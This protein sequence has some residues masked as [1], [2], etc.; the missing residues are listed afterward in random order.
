MKSKK[1][2]VV[3]AGLQGAAAAL[4]LASTGIKVDL[5]EREP[6][7]V[8][9]ASAQNECKIHLGYVFAKDTSLA[10][11]RVLSK[12]AFNFAPL[13]RRW[14]G[15]DF[16]KISVSAPFHYLVHKD[17]IVPV[18]EL[19]RFYEAVY[20]INLE[21]QENGDYLG[22]TVASAP[23]LVSGREDDGLYNPARVQ[24]VFRTHELGIDP[25]QLAAL[26][27]L[28]LAAQPDIRVITDAVVAE[29]QPSSDEVRLA[30][31][32]AGARHSESYD[33]VVNTAWDGRLA[34]D[35]KINLVPNRPWSF[36][37]KHFLRLEVDR[38]L[39]MPST[40]I[41]LGPFGDMVNYRNGAFHL[42]WYPAGMRGMSAD[43]VPPQ[44]WL[45]L[46]PEQ[47]AEVREGIM[48]GLVS[49]VPRLAMLKED[50]LERA[51]ISGGVIFAW[52]D[53]DIDDP[54]SELHQRYDIGPKSWGRYHS[55]DTGKL[56]MAP[57]F[58]KQVADR[59][60]ASF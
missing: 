44:Q 11:A 47:E 19:A 3:G 1:V 26:V 40:T 5:Y 7:C 30:F 6:A 51:Q 48:N 37:V 12:G 23:T 39:E 18:D 14:L 45:P 50:A 13:M 34:L 42:S 46:P 53:R 8:S 29:V 32:H 10:T 56:T 4:E 17:S 43:L 33:H 55:V 24:A 25:Q 20:A 41:V 54:S 35:A 31:D 21:D 16:D 58:G 2:A 27:R 9:R 57:L 15:D 38:T 22:A 59:I 49:V 36:R 52:G 60:R 28:R